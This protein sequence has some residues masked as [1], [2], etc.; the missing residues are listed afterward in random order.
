MVPAQAPCINAAGGWAEA[1]Q[2]GA[3]IDVTALVLRND[4][5]EAQRTYEAGANGSCD[6]DPVQ[7]MFRAAHA[8]AGHFSF[9]TD[10]QL[11]PW[12]P[13]ALGGRCTSPSL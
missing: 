2:E 8:A 3:Q 5:Q 4:C 12:G 6:R 10:A 11:P 7:R 9:S 13:V 1:D